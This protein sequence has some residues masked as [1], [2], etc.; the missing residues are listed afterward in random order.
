[1]HEVK[2]LIFD[3]G[4]VVFDLSFDR[5]Y[6]HWAE[7]SGKSFEEIR[8]KFFFDEVFELFEKNAITPE[9]FRS[10]IKSRLDLEISD[11]DFD[12]GWCNL[13]MDEF[14]GIDE[15]LEKLKLQF[16]IVALT[17]TN[18]IHNPVWREKYKDTLLYFERIF[19]SHELYVRKPEPEIYNM[20]LDYLKLEPQQAIFLDDNIDNVEGARAVG[21]TGLLIESFDQMKDD[22]RNFGILG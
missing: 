15:L 3:L 20:V 22:L 7:S 11:S 2:A 13:Y 16:R 10:S 18:I 12:A 6:I 4:K 9:Q 1:M 21:I 19:S 17:N 14:P 8:Q 5:V